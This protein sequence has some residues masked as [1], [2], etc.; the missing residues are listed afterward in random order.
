MDNVTYIENWFLEK[1]QFLKDR[2]DKYQ[3]LHILVFWVLVFES[4]EKI[5]EDKINLYME[6]KKGISLSKLTIKYKVNPEA[7]KYIVRLI[8]KH[9]FDIIKTTKIKKYPIREKERIINRVLLNNESL[10]SV[11]VDEGL[12]NYG[13]LSSWISKYKENGYNIV[14]HKRGRS[15]T[16][17]KKD[18]KP[19]V[20]ETIEEENE[21]LRKENLYLKAELEY[22]KKLR[23]VVQ[24]R[25]NQQQKK[26]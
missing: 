18:L 13:M 10:K 26:K 6:K 3:M 22:S 23:A 7:I 1:N 12:S 21:R 16:M 2:N 8:D 9:G 15:P 19:K 11:A 17:P 20:N 25:K 5:N 4:F 14:E 24:A